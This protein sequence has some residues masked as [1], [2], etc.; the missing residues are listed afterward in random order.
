MV[1][2]AYPGTT[3]ARLAGDAVWACLAYPCSARPIYEALQGRLPLRPARVLPIKCPYLMEGEAV[4]VVEAVVERRK[5]WVEN[6][7]IL[8]LS[9]IHIE[10]LNGCRQ[11]YTRANSCLV[12]AMIAY[13]RA[14]YWSHRRPHGCRT[15]AKYYQQLLDLLTGCINRTAPPGSWERRAA[16]KLADR[17]LTMLALN[18]CHPAAL[19]PN[20]APGNQL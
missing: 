17:A 4:I 20:Y 15:A 14:V 5:R 6:G 7:Y 8:Y 12:E 3:L 18:G 19:N 1:A 2:K 16:E 13:T 9:P 11:P 10:E